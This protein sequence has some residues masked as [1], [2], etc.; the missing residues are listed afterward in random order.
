MPWDVRKEIHEIPAALRETLERGRPEY[1]RLIR[2]T[3]WGELPI[4]FL[5]AGEREAVALSG[6][7]ACESLLNWSAVVRAPQDFYAYCLPMLRPRSVVWCVSAGKGSPEMP[8][9]VKAVRARGA[10]ALALADNPEDPLISECDGA[11]R[12]WPGEEAQK[13]I[14]STICQMA[15]ANFIKLLLARSHK[16]AQPHFQTLE[17]EFVKM[18]EHLSWV[19]TQFPQAL[20]SLA[21]ELTARTEVT[22]LAGGAYYPAAALAAGFLHRLG[23]VRA[24]AFNVSSLPP[25]EFARLTPADALLVISGS[26]TPV[27]KRVH[28]V[29]EAVRRTGSRILSL[30][31]GNDPEVVRRSALSLRLP[32]LEETTGAIMSLSTLAWIAGQCSRF[33]KRRVRP[34]DDR[35]PAKNS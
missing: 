20:D 3:R 35:P 16:R 31:D 19:F 23:G 9:V 1:E 24:R 29:V 25:A 26:R 14:C 34:A 17:E 27:R 4:F 32:V 28:E 22:L 2:Q 13:G 5:A 18:P 10:T 12:V 21:S 33:D 7:L 8:A 30:T 11:F 15:A 6:A